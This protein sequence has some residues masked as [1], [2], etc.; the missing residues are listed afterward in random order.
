MKTS[1]QGLVLLVAVALSSCDG[2]TSGHRVE[3]RTRLVTDLDATHTVTTAM[4]WT[5]TLTRALV[6]T[7]E[8]HYYDGEPAFIA[9]VGPS[10]RGR[11]WAA[12]SPIGTAHA[13]PGHYIKGNGMGDVLPPFSADLLA[14]PI[15]LPDG[16]GISGM[17]RSA[18]FSFAPPSAGPVAVALGGHVA[19]AE[20]SAT[21]E[22]T[23]VHFAVSADLADVARTAKDGAVTGCVFDAVDMQ[24]SGTV[25][26]T[27]KPRVWFNYVDF[28]AL[29]PGTADAPTVIEPAAVAHVAFAIGL[30]QLSAYQFSYVPDATN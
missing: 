25:T 20:G 27:V 23:T 21:K 24:Q 8:L 30:A 16:A 4:G 15:D 17:V 14:T 11:L 2:G 19:L 18:T 12:L 5:V 3:L 28:G 29:P 7:G 1:R 13:H 6:S 26:V 10:W 9:S 22:G